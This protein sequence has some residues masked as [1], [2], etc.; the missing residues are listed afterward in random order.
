MKT[1][2]R[3]IG[4]WGLVLAVALVMCTSA[5]TP[6]AQVSVEAQ[7]PPG[8]TWA[9]TWDLAKSAI[10]ILFGLAVWF[11]AQ[12]LNCIEKK[13]DRLFDWKGHTDVRL[14]ALETEHKLRTG[15]DCHPRRRDGE[16]AEEDSGS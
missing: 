7:P 10:T 3:A 4:F 11:S 16:L 1:A 8:T 15:H 5:A 14:T 6:Q 9:G 12:K 2:I 13:F